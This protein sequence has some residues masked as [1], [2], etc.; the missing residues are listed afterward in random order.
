MRFNKNEVFELNNKKIKI[1]DLLGEG[2]QG[3][4]YLVTDGTNKY[5]FKY[6]FEIPSDDFKY[7]LKCNIKKEAPSKHFLWPKEYVE[8][9]DNTCGYIMDL[10]P[11]NFVSFVSYLNGKA[12]FK[13]QHTL[14]NWCLEL[15]LAFKKLHE[16]GYSYQDLNDGSFF[17]DPETGDILICDNDNV[18]GDKR[19]L[20][21]LGK[22]RYMA[23]E[24]VVS[25]A[26]NGQQ[27][28]P[29]IHSDRF[30]LAIILFLTLCLGNPFEG[31]RLKKY[32][33]VDEHSE[34]EMF[35]TNPIF[36]MHKDDKSNRPI[37]G[38]HTSVI[39]RWPLLPTYIKEAFHRTFVDGLKD[40][41]NERT[42][43][44]EWLRELTKYRD[45]LL[46]CSCHKQFIYGF[47][48]KK[49]NSNCPYC[50][51]KT[52]RFCYIQVGRRKIALEPNKSIY[53]FHLNKYS[54]EYNKVVAKVVVNKN[55]SALW[56]IKL[57]LDNDVLIKDQEGTV[58]NIL[59]SG[60]IPIVNNLKIKFSDECVAEIK[61]NKGE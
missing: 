28:M 31:E 45:E 9:E 15:C 27:Q 24:I 47:F 53:E 3:E 56:G 23:P 46:T 21:V 25:N 49:I 29:D 43:E 17:L 19:N 57:N 38:Y 60:V 36:V 39:K 59:G 22:M 37:R 30:S 54:S 1:L 52:K 41:E 42:T 16:L 44:L 14:I 58:K 61:V 18:T 34:Q 8:F 11:N 32:D 33:F 6:Y 26:N 51:N 10:R 7:N 48:E 13:T 4:V 35:G 40:R 12:T 50:N 55:N 5:A 2:G 20:G